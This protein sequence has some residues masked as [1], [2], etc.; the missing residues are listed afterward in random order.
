MKYI[1]LV[2]V[3]VILISCGVGISNTNT[4][5][6][7]EG[8][9]LK[10]DEYSYNVFFDDLTTEYRL[11]KYFFTANE[12]KAYKLVPKEVRRT[13][14]MN[15]WRMKDP[16]PVTE[17]NEYVEEIKNRIRYSNAYFTHYQQG[18]TTDRG[19]IYIKYGEPYEKGKDL[20]SG[21]SRF[22]NKSYEIWK[23]RVSE[24]M[25]YIFIDSQGYGNFRLIY[26]EGDGEQMQLPEW[27]SYLGDG[28]NESDLY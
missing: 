21:T 6:F 10:D 18:W 16:N 22:P 26:A 12:L 1:L 15:F 3:S 17:V 14:M 25:T 24:N 27:Q 9:D 13:F 11:A 28:F 7:K 23:Y 20:T 8:S 19:R 5:V 2:L 4:I